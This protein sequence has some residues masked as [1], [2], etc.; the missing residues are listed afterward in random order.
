[1]VVGDR[2]EEDGRVLAEAVTE[3]MLMCFR[4]W[5]PQVFLEPVVQGPVEEAEDVARADIHDT[6]RLVAARFERHP[7][8]T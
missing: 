8:D 3:H 1:V 6:A 7:E 2:L 5:D 4:S